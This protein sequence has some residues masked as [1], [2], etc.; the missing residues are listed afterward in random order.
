MWELK[1]K[2]HPVLS[3]DYGTINLP[4]KRAIYDHSPIWVR[5]GMLI[6][7]SCKVLMDANKILPIQEAKDTWGWPPSLFTDVSCF[8]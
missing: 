1:P 4:L 7:K 3:K 6:W 8:C 2:S 5:K